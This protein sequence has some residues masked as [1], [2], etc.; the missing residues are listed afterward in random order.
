MD[1]ETIT[2]YRPTGPKELELVAGAGYGRWPRRLQEQ[3]YFYPV[4]NEAYA[5][6]IAATWN[7]QDNGTGFVT[8]FCVKRMF[9]E[10]YPIRR[11]GGQQHVE[12]WIPAED[13]EE[14]N[15]NIVGLIEV[16]GEFS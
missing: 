10:R 15:D 1:E 11:V 8:R 14:L 9:L 2:V 7:V 16:V 12:W 6:E 5:R 3:P 13:L 4:A